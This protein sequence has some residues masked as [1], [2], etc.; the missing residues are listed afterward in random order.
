[1]AARFTYDRMSVVDLDARLK[2]LDM[3]WL[4]FCRITGMPP[5]KRT[6]FERGVEQIPPWVD[7]V[8][9]LWERMPGAISETRQWAAETISRDELEPDVSYPYLEQEDCDHAS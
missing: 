8:L 5:G 1:M 7:L 9:T 3:K 6:V 4:A 2:K